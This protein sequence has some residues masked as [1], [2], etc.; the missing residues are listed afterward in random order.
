MSSHECANEPLGWGSGV[1][2]SEDQNKVTVTNGDALKNALKGTDPK[3]IYIKG[4]IEISS[5][6]MNCELLI[7]NYEL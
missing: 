5:Q 4:T 1:T 7:M 6:N 3:T 2:G